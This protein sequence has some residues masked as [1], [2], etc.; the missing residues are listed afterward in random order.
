MNVEGWV[1]ILAALGGGGFMIQA[2]QLYKSWKEGA[3][4]RADEADER[5]IKRYEDRLTRLEL[6]ADADARY[7]ARLVSALGRAGIEIPD[8]V[9]D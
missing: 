2:F 5:L 3:R 8:R 6:R 7:I 1:A 9:D 4:L